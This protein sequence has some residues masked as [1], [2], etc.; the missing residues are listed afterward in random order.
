M[1]T[2]QIVII[3]LIIIIVIILLVFKLWKKQKPIAKVICLTKNEYDLVER[4]IQYYGYIFG[5]E[6]IILVDNNSTNPGVLQI[7]D[8]Y[9]KKGVTIIQENRK[10]SE[11]NE[12]MTEHMQRLK[13][14]CEWILPLETDEFIFWTSDIE[15]PIYSEVVCDFLRDV[16]VNISAMRYSMMLGSIVDPNNA[17]YKNGQYLDPVLHIT[18]F[19]NQNWDKYIVRADAFEQVSQWNHHANISHGEYIVIKELGILHYH[20]TGARRAFE[21]ALSVLESYNMYNNEDSFEVSLVKLRE[22]SQLQN[23]KQGHK[24]KY[25]VEVMETMISVYID[26]LK[27]PPTKYEMLYD[28]RF[29]ELIYNKIEKTNMDGYEILQVAKTLE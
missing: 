25:A 20:E 13:G 11:A 18:N 6:N 12:F 1:E 27:R 3:G 2:W 17:N 4:F 24:V 21:K 9:K 8:K 26:V 19:F 15:N 7:Y 23:I 14:T 28:H 10:F 5:Y 22:I 16:P 29:D